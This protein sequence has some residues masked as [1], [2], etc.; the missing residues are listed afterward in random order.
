MSCSDK[1]P[2]LDYSCKEIPPRELKHIRIPT[3]DM[4][5]RLKQQEVYFNYLNKI[6]GRYRS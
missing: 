2:D 5:K 6:Y 4:Q 3:C 1:L